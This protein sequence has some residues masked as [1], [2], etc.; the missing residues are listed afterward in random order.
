VRHGFDRLLRREV[1]VR[2]GQTLD[3][4]NL[5]VRAPAEIRGTVV[6]DAGRPVA[7][8]SV[9]HYE[10]GHDYSPFQAWT[11]D[12]GRYALQVAPEGEGWLVVM[13]AELG[14]AVLPVRDGA[15]KGA[16]R[17][18]LGREGRVRARLGEPRPLDASFLVGR[19]GFPF[20]WQPRTRHEGPWT[21]L[22]GLPEGPL[23]IYLISPGREISDRVDVAPGKTLER[24]YEGR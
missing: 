18:A 13:A 16:D 3:L 24:D 10:E 8:A 1:T 19:P 2:A 20:R 12:T 4:G 6:D 9:A 17:I 22:L 21:L 7:Q 15:A 14:A 5:V 23:D 11:P